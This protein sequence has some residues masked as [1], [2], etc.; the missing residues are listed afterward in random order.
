MCGT[1]Y[2]TNSETSKMITRLNFMKKLYLILPVVFAAFYAQF[3]VAAKQDLNQLKAG[4]KADIEATRLSSPAGNN[5]LEKIDA[6]RAQA[7]FDF[8]IVPL[9]YDWGR[10]Y[11]A[12]ANNAIAAK[13][14]SQAESYLNNVWAVA[15]LTP[16]L[17]AA[18][19]KLDSVYKPSEAASQAA[20]QQ[21]IERQKQLA[22]A[23]AKERARAEAD[24]KKRIEAEK[25]QAELAKKKAA[26]DSARRQEEERQRRLA[27]E[28]ESAAKAQAAKAAASAPV[29]PA[30][31]SSVAVTPPVAAPVVAAVTNQAAA[32]L[33]NETEENSEPIASYPIAAE[34]IRQRDRGIAETLQP[35]CQAIVD[36]DASVVVH[37]E[38]KSDY[39]WLIVRLTLCLRQADSN[40]RL[41]HS[42]QEGLVE[43]EP[44]INLHSSR[45]VSL[46]RQTADEND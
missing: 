38:N 22:E 17:E 1:L 30:A 23:A 2:F 20:N 31:A 40:F 43:G 35:I 21:E 25:Q 26:E 29:K 41:R 34:Q 27:A 36:N 46:L 39:R 16:G 32:A 24:R 9:V 3:A 45:E 37:T 42:Y 12:L 5:A 15:A 14:Y 11:V 28:K 44:V 7:P 13:N 8:T 4:I 6:Y 10:A 19:E 18:Q 33:W